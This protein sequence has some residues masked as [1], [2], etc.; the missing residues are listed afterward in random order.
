MTGEVFA[1]GSLRV[2]GPLSLHGT[3]GYGHSTQILGYGAR[4]FTLGAGV[5]ADG[6]WP[7][8]GDEVCLIGGADAGLWHRLFDDPGP[9]ICLFGP[10]CDTTPVPKPSDDR[11]LY[12]QVHVGLV[13]RT[14]HLQA[15]LV[16]HVTSG[17]VDREAAGTAPSTG[18]A[19]VY[20]WGFGPTIGYLF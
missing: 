3:I 5:E 9:S 15:G 11:M 1:D 12:T 16:V 18:P 7:W 8:H 14:G 4:V 19:R 17:V 6:C 13:G 20:K 10:P 2:I